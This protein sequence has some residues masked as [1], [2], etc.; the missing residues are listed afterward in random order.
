VKT[1]WEVVP[2]YRHL[3]ERAEGSA[4]KD[5]GPQVRREDTGPTE[6]GVDAG[7]RM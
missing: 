3:P 4:G 6:I 1:Q 7:N 5:R 2:R